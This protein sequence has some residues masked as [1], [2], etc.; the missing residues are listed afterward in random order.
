MTARLEALQVHTSGAVSG[1]GVLTDVNEG[2]ICA[3]PVLSDVELSGSNAGA[4]VGTNAGVILASYHT[5]ATSG[6][7]PVGGLVGSNSGTLVGCYQAG[8]VTGENIVANSTG[9]VEACLY[10]ADSMT[11]PAFT[12]ELNSGIASWCASH[13][14]Y[15]VHTYVHQPAGYPHL[16]E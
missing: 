2:M 1:R 15:H 5:G 11:R 10:T 7:A 13:A 4:L 14:G 16:S 8:K 6:S 12:E 3:C 9:E